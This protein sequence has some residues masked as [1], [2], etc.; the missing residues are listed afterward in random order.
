VLPR[1][2][3]HVAVQGGIPVEERD[4]V[5]VLVE[6]VMAELPVIC[7]HLADEAAP[8]EMPANRLEVH[9][10]RSQRGAARIG[11]EPL[12]DLRAHAHVRDEAPVIKPGKLEL[13]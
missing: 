10:T 11:S 13:I 6:D 3:D 2:D 5:R 8:T 12:G 9:R 4:S 1:R 7:E